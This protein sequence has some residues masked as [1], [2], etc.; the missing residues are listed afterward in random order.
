MFE[1]FDPELPKLKSVVGENGRAEARR[2]GSTKFQITVSKAPRVVGP[3]DISSKIAG[4]DAFVQS[5]NRLDDELIISIV[6]PAYT[7]SETVE[8]FLRLNGDPKNS[9]IF[10]ITYIDDSLPSIVGVSPST[11]PDFGVTV[12][13]IQLTNFPIVTETH[14]V[15]V[16]FGSTGAYFGTSISIISSNVDSTLLQVQVPAFPVAKHEVNAPIVVKSVRQTNRVSLPCVFHFQ[17]KGIS[18]E[19]LEPMQTSILGGTTVYIIKVAFFPVGLDNNVIA[20]E[21]GDVLVHPQNISVTSSAVESTIM[22]I[23]TPQSDAGM[24]K[25]RI[26]L[27]TKGRSTSMLFDFKFIDDFSPAICAPF[28]ARSCISTKGQT[29]T[30]WV[31]YLQENIANSSQVNVSFGMYDAG[32]ARVLSRER[33]LARLVVDVPSIANVS[34]SVIATLVTEFGRIAFEYGFVD[35]SVPA[36]EQMGQSNKWIP[37]VE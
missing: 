28:P 1:Y 35:C 17:K 9:V 18:I 25:G 15:I 16:Q 23:V 34:G 12:V 3:A 11:A 37:E 6:A 31:T 26:Y 14:A 13:F 20:V 7:A 24:V 4:Q 5:L 22:V 29:E 2:S 36:I 32:K 10:A 19:S 8:G 33:G 21:F 30:I 27:N